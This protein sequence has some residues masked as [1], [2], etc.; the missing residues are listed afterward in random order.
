MIKNLTYMVIYILIS[1]V[2]SSNLVYAQPQQAYIKL[3]EKYGAK[4]ASQYKFNKSDEKEFLR[5]ADEN[6]E[7]YEKSILKEH[8]EYHLKEAM[9]YYFLLEKANS[10]SIDAQIG[11]G[12]VYDEMNQDRL[13]K[14]YFFNA[15]NFDK[16][17]PKMNLYLADFYYKRHDFVTA[18]RYYDMAYKYGYA[19]N[20]S[21]N[22]QM[23][24]LHE[25]LADI[26]NAKRYYRTAL[27]LNPKNVEL[28][29]KIGSLEKLNY[30]QSQY[31]LFHK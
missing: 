31:Y 7:Q 18:F 30:S 22:Y 6:M 4:P 25:K 24:L 14:K 23:G 28:H 10:S 20:Y 2:I 26:E 29:H 9:H 27:A 1:S 11:L 3:V 19:N 15:Y 13:A 21:L 16:N 17:N 12:R 5:K 8:R